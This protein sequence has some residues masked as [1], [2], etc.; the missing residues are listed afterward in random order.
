MGK[1]SFLERRPADGTVDK[2]LVNCDM[3]GYGR[4]TFRRQ[5][6]EKAKERKKAAKQE[7]FSKSRIE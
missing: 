5:Q 7:S 4:A 2:E 3:V 6:R 1:A